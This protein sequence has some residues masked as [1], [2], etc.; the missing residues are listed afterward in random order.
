MSE[1]W[2]IPAPTNLGPKTTCFDDMLVNGN[3]NGIYF[4]SKHDICNWG[5]ALQTTRGLLH[6]LN[7]TWTLV[8]KWLKTG[9][10]FYSPFI[11]SA[12]YSILLPGFTDG[13]TEI[14]KRNL[15]TLC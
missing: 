12:F 14:S 1:I 2:G 4:P 11:N 10:A 15:T 6:R 13:L 3:F 8:N 7:M 5:H 9:P